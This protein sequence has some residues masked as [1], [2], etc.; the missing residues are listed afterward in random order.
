MGLKFYNFYI[1]FVI[2]STWSIKLEITLRIDLLEFEGVRLD[3]L[4]IS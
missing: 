2:M 4:E 3:Y 1:D